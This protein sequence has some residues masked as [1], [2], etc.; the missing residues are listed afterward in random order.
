M[1]INVEKCKIM[2]FGRTNKRDKYSMEDSSGTVNELSHSDTER[3]L[4]IMVSEDL[5][6]WA[7][8]ENVVKKANIILGMLK[9]RFYSRDPRLWRNLYV[10]LK[11]IEDT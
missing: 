10:A 1:K 11:S 2:H 6:W 3:N 8:I 4:G 5:S 7:H 9:R